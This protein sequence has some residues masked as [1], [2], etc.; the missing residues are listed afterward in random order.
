MLLLLVENFWWAASWPFYTWLLAV[1]KAWGADGF[2]PPSQT[3]APDRAQVRRQGVC[4]QESVMASDS[5]KPAIPEP[6]RQPVK[7]SI[8][9]ARRA[10]EAFISTSEKT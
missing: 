3:P 2:K 1:E 8:E 10:F 7:M 6:P 9:Q 4:Q 5:F